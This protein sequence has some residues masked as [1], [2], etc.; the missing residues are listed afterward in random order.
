MAPDDPA[1]SDTFGWVLYR[2]RD[3]PR[4]LALVQFSASKLPGQPEILYHLGMVHYRMGEE[5]AAKVALQSALQLSRQE[6]WRSEA[7]ARL[8]I[9]EIDAQSADAKTVIE[10]QTSLQRDAEDPILLTRLAQVAAREGNWKEAASKYEKALVTNDHLVPVMVALGR[11][12]A[13]HLNDP[14]RAMILA[15][16]ARTLEPDDPV[17]AHTLGRLA[18]ES[19]RS[20]NDFQW[21]FSLLQESLSKLPKDP[22]VLFDY[23]L[24]SYA[25]GRVD[26]AAEAMRRAV[27]LELPPVLTNDAGIFLRMQ[28]L[29]S[30]PNLAVANAGE[31]ADLI[32]KEPNHLAALVT[33]AVIQE[34]KGN[35]AD[36][37]DNYE[38]VL[39]LA[40]LFA[41]ANRAL[42]GLYFNNLKDPQRAFDH[43]MKAREVFPQDTRNARILGVLSYQRSEFSS[44][45]MLL[46]ESAAK[47]P[48][49]SEIL[50]CLGLSQ[51]KLKQTGESKNNLTKA[52]AMAPNSALAPEAKRVLAEIK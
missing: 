13:N 21:A 2:N 8:R 28:T 16:Q 30:D 15:R 23:A 29:Q 35:H 26:S 4:A 50:Y 43:A 12:Y 48:E 25:A 14:Q 32:H 44:A 7:Q 9:L 46:K 22:R 6:A 1:T 38:K 3:Y 11:I 18:F 10:L 40:P 41:P 42:A 47:Y 19:A 5:A 51:F 36:A 33:V 31:V 17:I 49:D 20:P 27:A 45:A 24:A 34:R 37:R 39:K 52:L